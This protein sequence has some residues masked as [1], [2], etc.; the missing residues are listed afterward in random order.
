[1]DL[2]YTQYCPLNEVYI[3]LYA[4][5]G[6]GADDEGAAD[7]EAQALGRAKPPLWAEVEKRMENGGLDEL[8]NGI[9]KP[10]ASH[11]KPPKVKPRSI[12]KPPDK[13]IVSKA[14]SDR[15]SVKKGESRS[16]R[17]KKQFAVKDKIVVNEKEDSDNGHM[18]DGGFFEEL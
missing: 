10:L 18:S 12:P 17:R 4:T 9:R 14:I 15:S 11:P 6:S 8:R 5:S 7:D 13:V 3:G 16:E 1:V 2:K